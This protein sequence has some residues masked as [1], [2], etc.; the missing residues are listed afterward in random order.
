MP[1]SSLKSKL[2]MLEGR[3]T[4][5]GDSNLPSNPTARSTSPRSQEAA[6]L[7]HA[8][9]AA[10]GHQCSQYLIISAI[11]ARNLVAKDYDT[12]SSDP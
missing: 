11:E 1:I 4:D 10:E 9:A 7:E 6:A 12:H 2:K 5:L 8:A 3:G